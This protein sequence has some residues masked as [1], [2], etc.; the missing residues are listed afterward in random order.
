MVITIHT[1]NGLAAEI[2][3]FVKKLDAK[4]FADGILAPLN[5]DFSDRY[6]IARS[7]FVMRLRCVNATAASASAPPNHVLGSGAAIRVKPVDV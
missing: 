1:V 2:L 4:Q 6:A 7:R 3:F 5:R